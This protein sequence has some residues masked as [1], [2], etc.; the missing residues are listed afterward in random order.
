MTRIVLLPLDDRPLNYAAV[1]RATAASQVEVALPPRELVGSRAQAPELFPAAR[2]LMSNCSGNALVLSLDALL[3]G[4]LVQARAAKPSIPR[5]QEALKLLAPLASR[6][7]S[8]RSFLVWKRVWGN[9]FTSRGL[10]RMLVFQQASVRLAELARESGVHSL[11]ARLA[12]QP[13]PLCGL[14]ADDVLL[15]AQSRLAMLYEAKAIVQSCASAGIVLHI[16]VED[17]TIGGVQE[18]ELAWLRSNTDAPFTIADG[19]DEV[20]AVFVASAINESLGSLPL[21]AYASTSLGIIAPYESRTIEENLRVLCQLA[22]VKLAQEQA[23][24]VLHIA[25][26]PEAGDLYTSLLAG[27]LA[28]AKPEELLDTMIPAEEFSWRVACDLTATNGIN[29][30]LLQSFAEDRTPPLAIVQMNT[31]SNRIGHAL[32][33]AAVVS[34]SNPTDELAKLIIASYCEDL[35]YQAHLRTRAVNKYG[36]IEPGND[37]V[38]VEAEQSLSLLATAFA[39]RKFSGALLL[40]KRINAGSVHVRLP[41]RRWFECEIEAEAELV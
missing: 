16:A 25:G 39:K 4:G 34:E 17:S 14:P 31:V 27:E 20:G 13:E 3:H 22:R 37:A 29:P 9:I 12:S 24:S 38:L 28:A 8:I 2:W 19:A 30:N 5:A 35:L 1:L 6:A 41:W 15:M 7:A 36:G 11:Y 10:A 32:L 18:E 40:G 21:S 26:Q 33:L 23:G